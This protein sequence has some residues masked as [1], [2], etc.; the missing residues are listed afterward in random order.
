MKQKRF[1]GSG[2]TLYFYTSTLKCSV[3]RGELP[4]ELPFKMGLSGSLINIDVSFEG[5][6]A[7]FSA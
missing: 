3:I 2:V 5:A 7:S 6:G 4:Y 1:E